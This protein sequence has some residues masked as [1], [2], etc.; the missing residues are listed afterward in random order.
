MN[1]DP[2]RVLPMVQST[3]LHLHSLQTKRI[4]HPLSTVP[5]TPCHLL[6]ADDILI[7]MKG[8]TQSVRALQD[9]LELYQTASGQFFNLYK[10]LLKFGKCGR[11]RKRKIS[12]T[13]RIQETI[14]QLTYLGIPIVFGIPEK[15]HFL[16]LIDSVNKRL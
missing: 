10:S 5:S 11:R 14:V 1:R 13:L 16:P 12:A 7:F 4:I 6:F 2:L 8:A 15:S 9:L 3:H